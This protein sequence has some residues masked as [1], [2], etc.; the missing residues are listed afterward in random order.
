MIECSQQIT[1]TDEAQRRARSTRR[2][3]LDVYGNIWLPPDPDGI[4]ICGG[5]SRTLTLEDFPFKQEQK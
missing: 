3:Q 4:P 2:P 1:E 5:N